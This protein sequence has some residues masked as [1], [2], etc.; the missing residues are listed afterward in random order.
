MVPGVTAW[1]VRRAFVRIAAALLALWV[2]AAPRA[3]QPAQGQA[4]GAEVTPYSGFGG[5]VQTTTADSTAAPLQNPQARQGS[6]NIIYLVLDDVGFADLGAYGSEIAT[7]NIDAL[8]KAGLRYNNFHTHAIC[9]TT[10]AALLTGRVAHAVGMK[11]LAGA[12]GGYPN[13]RGRITPAAATIAQILQTG[14]YATYG[15][16]KWHLTPAED[17]SPSSPRTHWPLQKG[18]DR[19]Y[20]FLS[21]WTDQFHPSLIE[22]NHSLTTP[23]HAGYHFTEDI[24]DRTIE[25]LREGQAAGNGRPFFMYFATGAAHAPIQAP[26]AYIAKYTN[27][28]SKGWDAIRAERYARQKQMGLIPQDTVMPPRNPDDRAWADLTSDERKVF[29]RY[30]AVY[31]GFIEHTDAQIGRLVTYLKDSSQFDNTVIFLISDNGAAPEAGAEGGFTSPYGGK[32]SIADSL[33]R[34]DDL[35]TERSQ[36]LYQRPWAMAGV[37]PFK[38]YKLSMQL[39]GVRDPLIV[40]WPK[41]IAAADN[42]AV[43]AQFIDV[44]DLTPTVLEVAGV[45]APDVFQGVPQMPIH[46]RSILATIR[47]GTAANPRDT[48]VFE[49]RGERAIYDHGWRAVSVHAPG[50]PY[51]QDAWELYDVTH[52]YAEASNLAAKKPE[53]LKA[54][55]DLWWSEARKYGVLPLTAR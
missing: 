39:G 35:G 44:I 15:I 23:D 48:Q 19:Y 53:K 7:P 3:I 11:D 30:M 52:D 22:D 54:L 5:R 41:G 31:A 14:G 18:F 20:G 16:G 2:V 29:A 36:A 4:G 8:G 1:T 9:S 46:G 47:D 27:S 38:K 25:Y 26:P 10:R 32:L 45:Q 34:L 17:M 37:A 40:S 51:E 42:G 21:G 49:L 12:D 28:Y 24:V 33:A 6:P 55:Q 50:T 13:S 43:R